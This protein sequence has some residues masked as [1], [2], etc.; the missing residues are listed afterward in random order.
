M[1]RE[2]EKP[3]LT[4]ID[5]K[6]TDGTSTSKKDEDGHGTMKSENCKGVLDGHGV[7]NGH[8]LFSRQGFFR[9]V[10]GFRSH[11][12]ATTVRTTECVHTLTCRTHIFLY[13]RTSSCVSPWL[14]SCQKGVCCTC[15]IPLHLAFSF[16]MIHPFLLFLH[17]HFETNPDYDFTDSDIHKFLTYFPVLE[18]QDTRNSAHASR[19][20]A[21]W[22]DQM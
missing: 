12:V 16:L 11:V 13:F 6:P 1:P 21:T 4:M 19:S 20:L 9:H 8:F 3:P 10:L 18:A 2:T 5:E 7:M 15:V 14:K 17:G 22:P